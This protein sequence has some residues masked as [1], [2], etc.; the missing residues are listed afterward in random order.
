MEC[1]GYNNNKIIS[2]KKRR[3]A[4]KKCPY[5]QEEIQDEAIKCRFCGEYLKKKK[6]KN[7]LLVCLI[8]SVV[9]ILLIIAFIYFTSLILKFILHKVFFGTFHL[10]PYCYP[11][12]TGQGFE[13]ILRE[14]GEAFKALWERLKDFFHFGPHHYRITF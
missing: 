10:P 6:W 9:S 7:C 1:P 11:P 5:C 2:G 12:F 4:M 3:E 14:F 8:A 13:G